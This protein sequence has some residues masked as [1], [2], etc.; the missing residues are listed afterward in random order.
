VL[1]SDDSSATVIGQR[2]E[3]PEPSLQPLLDL[4]LAKEE[5]AKL[6]D[7][8]GNLFS[9]WE[10]TTTWWRHFGRSRPLL[11]TAARA[12]DGSLLA[13]L[14]IYLSATRPL[15]IARF[16]G[17]GVGD[18]LGPICESLHRQA[19][20]HALRSVLAQHSRRCDV[21]VGDGLPGDEG[22]GPMLGGTV[23]RRTSC[24]V[25][26]I[27]GASWDEF[28]AARS[29]NFREQVRSRERRLARA[30]K[31]R[32]RLADDPNRLQSDLDS[33]FTLHE[34]RWGERRSYSL[35]GA[36][37]EFHRDFAARALE[38]GWLRL[39]FLELDG[40]AAAAWY[41]FR[42]AGAEWYYQMGRDPA[43]ERQ[44]VGFVL[45][46]HSIREAVN[47]GMREY[48]LLLGDE[49]YKSRFADEDPGLEA[50]VVPRG[51]RGRAA[52]AG[53]RAARR[54]PQPIGDRLLSLAG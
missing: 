24:P 40:R 1:R 6:V 13:I 39:W 11:V 30:H 15:R 38:R 19:A 54:L 45:L 9:T 33:L 51:V 4:E 23:L 10:W 44:S 12:A 50:V 53:A 28:L 14:P 46:A 17:H 26:R 41:G 3:E 32:Y 52:L 47:D 29:S 18:Q 22:W 25:L 49:P 42:F 34:A 37:A 16:I 35:H 31:L 36:R 21:F 8:A 48:K 27:D 7:R 2:D 20:A 43:W 5:W